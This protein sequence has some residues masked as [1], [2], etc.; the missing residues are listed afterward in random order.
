MLEN[1]ELAPFVPIT[2]E[3]APPVPPPPTVTVIAEP[4]DTANP[5]AVL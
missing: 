4:V 3:L 1:T 5:L 2:P